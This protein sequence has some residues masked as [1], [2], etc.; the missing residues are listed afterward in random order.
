LEWITMG[1]GRRIYDLTAAA[2][3]ARDDVSILPLTSEENKSLEPDMLKAIESETGTAIFFREVSD[4]ELFPVGSYITISRGG[5]TYQAE[6]TE[7]CGGSQG[8]ESLSLKLTMKASQSSRDDQPLQVEQLLIFGSDEGLT[9]YT[10]RRLAMQKVREILDS[11]GRQSAASVEPERSQWS[12][13]GGQDRGGWSNWKSS[14]P[15]APRDQ[16]GSRA[17]WQDDSGASK[18]KDDW[19]ASSKDD[20]GASKSKPEDNSWSSWKA[21]G[22][23][24]K[25]ADSWGNE[26]K[27]D[28][29][30]GGASG[31]ARQRT[32][33]A[34]AKTSLD[35]RGSSGSGDWAKWTK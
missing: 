6:V 20:W 17:T 14:G 25:E 16:R 29:W 5:R 35:S 22:G 13:A 32:R 30:G 21:G 12:S 7:S 2:L 34:G 11:N 3:Q 1:R 15:D 28:S 8:G 31:G 4:A 26:T 18:S 24:S 9:G 27:A 10:G 23:N 33:S 19:G